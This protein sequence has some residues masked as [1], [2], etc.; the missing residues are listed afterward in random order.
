MASELVLLELLVAPLKKGA[1]DVADEIELTGAAN[2][3]TSSG[4]LLLQPQTIGQ[5][6]EIGGAGGTAAFDIT[7]TEIGKLTDGFASITVGQNTGT[8]AVTINNTTFTDNL[9]V[10][11]GSIASNGTL[12][13]TGNTVNLTANT[14]GI[15][16]G[17]GTASNVV[18][19]TLN[20]TAVGNIAL[21]TQVGT[22]NATSTTGDITL[23]EA[24]GVSLGNVSAPVGSLDITTTTGNLDVGSLTAGTTNNRFALLFAPAGA[25][26]DGN[27]GT[28]N[29]TAANIE[30]LARNGINLDTQARNTDMTVANFPALQTSR[31][32]AGTITAVNAGIADINIR[33]V[34]NADI[35]NVATASD[36]NTS[37]NITITGTTNLSVNTVTAGGLI[38]FGANPSINTR[39][40]GGNMLIT[41]NSPRASS[42]L[43]D[44]T[45]T[46]T[47]GSLVP[48][49]ETSSS[50]GPGNVAV[51]ERIV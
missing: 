43:T 42:N 37:G 27:G 8:G 20:A 24:N 26:T 23:V 38:A 32:N 36:T 14:G 13:S 2:S 18:A 31:T 33:Q 10:I 34:G 6:I 29:I 11:G 9:T 50:G 25:I 17:N 21:D 51:I 3:I 46:I 22:I 12:T 7:N 1:Q 48:V 5:N 15:S 41:L 30:L 44:P 40:V 39:S 4:N 45:V 19:G 49:N 35:L 28:V 47:G 16:D